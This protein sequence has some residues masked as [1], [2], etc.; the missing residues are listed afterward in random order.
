MNTDKLLVFL[1]AFLAYVA[2]DITKFREA[3]AID[4]N[5]KFDW[6]MAILRWVSGALVGGAGATIV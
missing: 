6:V 3:R 1:S 5:V 4:P 2:Y